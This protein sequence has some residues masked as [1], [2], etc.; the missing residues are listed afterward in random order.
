[1]AGAQVTEIGG[2]FWVYPCLRN[3][4][5]LPL[6]IP[7]LQNNEPYTIQIAYFVLLTEEINNQLLKH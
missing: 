3:T 5:D 4:P 6:L 7:L 1:M 2:G